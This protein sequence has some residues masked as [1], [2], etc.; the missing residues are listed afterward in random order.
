VVRVGQGRHHEDI[1]CEL[2]ALERKK[3]VRHASVV[4][5]RFGVEKVVALIL[6]K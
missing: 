6:M 4:Q 5:S 1:A 3:Q 2:V